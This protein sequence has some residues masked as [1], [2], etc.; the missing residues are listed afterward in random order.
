MKW[1]WTFSISFLSLTETL[2][3]N[4]PKAIY[5]PSGVQEQHKILLLYLFFST[6]ETS[7]VH[8]EKSAIPPLKSFFFLENQRKMF[9]YLGSQRVESQ[10]LNCICMC[11]FEFWGEIVSPDHHTF[12]R[13]SSGKSF[14]IFRTCQT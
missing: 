8:N 12:I 9:I 11:I 7:G 3:L 13:T 6:L 14:A 1:K 5:W 2:P 4:V 10:T